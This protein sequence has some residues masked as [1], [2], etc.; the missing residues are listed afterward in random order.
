MIFLRSHAPALLTGLNLL[1]A[2]FLFFSYD[3]F[4]LI[5]TGYRGADPLLSLDLSAVKSIAYEDPGL[6]LNIRLMRG[7]VR[8]SSKEKGKAP[9]YAWDLVVRKDGR[10][11]YLAADRERVTEL[12]KAIE[13]SRRYYPVPRSPE[14]D[15][16]LQMGRNSQGEVESPRI[17]VEYNRG[18]KDTI[19]IGKTSARAGESYVRLNDESSIYLVETDLRSLTGQGDV[20]Y[21]RNRRVLPDSLTA[22]SL[23]AVELKRGK[24]TVQLVRKAGSWEMLLPLQGKLKAAE[25]TALI[26]EIT[27]WKANSFLEKSPG[28]EKDSSFELTLEFKGPGEEKETLQIKGL[29][30]SD[31]SSFVLSLPGKD[32][33]IVEVTGIQL[34]DLMETPERLLEGNEQPILE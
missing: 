17:I 23:T 3:P 13:D 1:L 25:S 5:E 34:R 2:V 15:S 22:E 18:N 9:E 16:E 31:Y 8:P 27:G 7:E 33:E 6:K 14:K 4:R 29:G 26:S 11:E 28:L 30:K 21:F 20:A 24:K 19:Y 10:E 12:L 32:K